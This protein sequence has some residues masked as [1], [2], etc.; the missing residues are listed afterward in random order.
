MSDTISAKEAVAKAVNQ[1]AEGAEQAAREIT[2]NARG[3]KSGEGSNK[4]VLKALVLGPVMKENLTTGGPK[5]AP[6]ESK[7]LEHD[8][9]LVELTRDGK[10]IDPPFDKLVLAMLPEHSTQL[11]S[12]HEAMAV[13]IDGFGHRFVPRIKSDDDTDESIRKEIAKERAMLANFFTHCCQEV[14][15]FVELRKRTRH[16]IES[17]GEGYWEVIRGPDGKLQGLEHMKSHQIRLGVL[18]DESTTYERLEAHLQPGGSVVLEKVT[19]RRRFRKYIQAR[20]FSFR[21]GSQV[22][23]FRKRWFKEYGDPRIIDNETGEVV[24]GDAATELPFSRQAGE[25]IRWDIYNPRTPY[26]LP[27]HIGCLLTIY[28]DRAADEINYVTFRNNNIPSMI[29]SVSNGEVTE[30]SI[31]RIQSFVESQIHGSDN[32][33]RFL[34]IEA[35]S[36]GVDGE[37]TGHAKIEITPLGSTQVKDFLFGNYKENNRRTL[38]E[39]Y[40]LPPIFV[41]AS[42]DYTR[43]TAESSRKLGDEQV[44]SPERNEVDAVINRTIMPELGAVYHTF[45]SNG[46]NVTDDEDLIKVMGVAERTGGLTPRIAR[47]ILTDILNIDEA[48]LP[49]LSPDVDLDI[50][51]S[52]QLA[53]AVKNQAPMDAQLAVKGMLANPDPGGLVGQLLAF[54][55]LAEQRW[56]AGLAE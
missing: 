45:K 2:D 30:D 24:A 53:D 37:D 15:S 6:A 46:P 23:G 32:Y 11:Y 31:E 17:T 34:I 52:L 38:R 56:L 48:D 14:P 9:L 12:I 26:G 33:S 55:D 29:I 27:R 4:R 25:L 41:G 50:P 21:R 8:D 40:R 49:P 42:D 18:D 3:G 35:E 28:G 22:R 19:R 36:P 54:R 51:F 39:A 43:A 20:V 5:D 16:D 1:I 7:G 10:I 13:N 47:L 44:F